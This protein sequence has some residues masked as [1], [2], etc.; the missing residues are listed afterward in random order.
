MGTIPQKT[1]KRKKNEDKFLFKD[2]YNK[3][4]EAHTHTHLIQMIHECC[5]HLTF[6]AIRSFLI[7]FFFLLYF[8]VIKRF[9]KLYVT[10]GIRL[11]GIY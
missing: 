8:V 7:L 9:S 1:S 11:Y 6:I 3:C 2:Y 4:V 5:D 10:K